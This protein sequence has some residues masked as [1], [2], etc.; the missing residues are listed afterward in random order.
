[1]RREH[2][3]FCVTTFNIDLT[4][5][6]ILHFFESLDSNHDGE[7]D[8][9]EFIQGVYPNGFQSIQSYGNIMDSAGKQGTVLFSDELH[10]VVSRGAQ[11]V[12]SRYSQASFTAPK[13]QKQP[14]EPHEYLDLPYFF[15]MKLQNLHLNQ[16]KMVGLSR[17]KR[18]LSI[19][20]STPKE[21][22]RKSVAGSTTS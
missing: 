13:F 2:F 10:S 20:S 6:E 17:P 1:V 22:D 15:K 18:A 5:G 3:W 7:I 16:G 12:H 9:R 19:V 14:M 21:A 4:F 11:S 8:E